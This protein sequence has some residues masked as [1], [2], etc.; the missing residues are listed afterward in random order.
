MSDSHVHSEISSGLDLSRCFACCHNHCEFMLAAVLLSILLSHHLLLAL[1]L[2]LSPLPQWSLSLGKMIFSVYVAVSISNLWSFI[3][4]TFLVL[5]L[6]PST[7][8]RSFPDGWWEKHWSV[9]IAISLGFSLILNPISKII[10][11]SLPRFWTNNSARYEFHL[12]GWSSHPIRK[13][14]LLPWCSYHFCTSGLL[15]LAF[16]ASEDL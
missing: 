14:L 2:T 5:S 12:V 6:S 10:V 15:P 1:A 11:G 9:G 3:L 8:S 4:C 13:Q 16:L 7:A